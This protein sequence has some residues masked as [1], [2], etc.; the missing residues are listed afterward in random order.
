MFYNIYILYSIFYILY[1]IFYILY[2]N[3]EKKITI[4]VEI[5]IPLARIFNKI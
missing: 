3:I 4:L 2:E 1:S 5:S